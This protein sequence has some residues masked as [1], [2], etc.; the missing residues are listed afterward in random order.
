[1]ASYLVNRCMAQDNA[2]WAEGLLRCHLLKMAL[3][4]EATNHPAA[5]DCL[6]PGRLVGS[7]FNFV[8]DSLASL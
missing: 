6:V 2:V 7:I 1:M 5:G 3:T 4:Q 8:V